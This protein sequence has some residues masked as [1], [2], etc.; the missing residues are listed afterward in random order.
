MLQ[1]FLGRQGP[2]DVLLFYMK[3]TARC[4]SV[5]LRVPLILRTARPSHQ[6]QQQQQQ[7]QKQQQR[8][9]RRRSGPSGLMGPFLSLRFCWGPLLLT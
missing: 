5:I 7:Q 2:L 6:Q 9:H 1:L 8:G 4:V 3:E